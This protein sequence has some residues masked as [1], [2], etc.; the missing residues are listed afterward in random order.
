MSTA[1][2]V[3]FIHKE[4]TSRPHGIWFLSEERSTRQLGYSGASVLRSAADIQGTGLSFSWERCSRE[5][6]TSHP[7]E[8]GTY[9]YR[10]GG[11]SNPHHYCTHHGSENPLTHKSTRAALP[12]AEI[13]HLFKIGQDHVLFPLVRLKIPLLSLVSASLFEEKSGGGSGEEEDS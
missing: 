9:R 12:V 5:R 11:N 6:K 7:Q 13:F 2:T 4:P 10:S 1:P 8:G 3:S